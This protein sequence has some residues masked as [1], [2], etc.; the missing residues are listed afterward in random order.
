M[1]P[2]SILIVYA[3]PA[4][5]AS[6]VNRRLAQAA[7]ALPHTEVHELYERYPDFY[8]D[9]AAEQARLAAADHVVFV[10]PIQWYSAPALL[11]EWVDVVL[12]PGWAY[13][14]EGKALAGKTYWLVTTTGSAQDAYSAGGPHG[15][16]FDDYLPQFRQT[17]A[18][19]GM[20]WEE[21]LVL[22]GAHLVDDAALEAHVAAFLARL[23]QLSTLKIG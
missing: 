20:R 2:P 23:E 10:H 9:V 1:K 22:H 11:K 4:P 13:G 19:C 5:H 21:P 12:Q 14:K 15:R 7:R 16:P 3:H 17:A 18:L 8:I 6:R